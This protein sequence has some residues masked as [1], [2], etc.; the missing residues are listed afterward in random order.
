MKVETIY[1]AFMGE[2]NKWGIGARCVFVRLSGCNL[3]CYKKTMGVLCDTPEALEMGSFK[4][5]LTVQQIVERVKATGIDLVCL[6]GGEPLLQKPM[7]LILELIQN[8]IRVAI[9]TNGS[10]NIHSYTGH[11][12][13]SIIVDYKSQSS[14]E[15][16]SFDVKN[17]AALT[18][19][20]FLKFVLY[21]DADYEEMLTVLTNVPKEVNVGVGLFWGSKIS[22]QW[23][24]A[25]LL[26]DKLDVMLN[27]QAHK[28]CVLYDGVKD[29]TLFEGIKIPQEL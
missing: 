29:T 15:G 23:L 4:E 26:S 28:M 11:Q 13:I 1:P 19:N 12:N 10:V 3:R 16:A 6:T 21:D 22:Y 5:E 25:R 27:M 20:D 9:E 18:K 2:V 7:P 17:F 14:G 24:M 8:N